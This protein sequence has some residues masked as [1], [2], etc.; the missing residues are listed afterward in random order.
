ML[1]FEVPEAE[2]EQVAADLCYLLAMTDDLPARVSP[3]AVV[4]VADTRDR[5]GSFL[6]TLQD[7]LGHGKQKVAA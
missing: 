5:L 3:G 7:A 1:E 4:A 6:R 2:I